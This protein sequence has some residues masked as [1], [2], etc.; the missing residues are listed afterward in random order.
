[1]NILLFKNETRD[2]VIILICTDLE[3]IYLK[4]TKNKNFTET[5]DILPGGE[6]CMD[7]IYLNQ[8]NSVYIINN[9]GLLHTQVIWFYFF[10]CRIDKLPK[11]V[12]FYFLF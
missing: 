7:I 6:Y 5:V 11:K 10:C 12:L 1:M 2:I 4:Q 3:I 8:K 9:D